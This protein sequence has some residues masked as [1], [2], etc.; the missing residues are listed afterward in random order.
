M[1]ARGG[2]HRMDHTLFGVE[3][4]ALF[5]TCRGYLNVS[6][7]FGIYNAEHN[8]LGEGKKVG[9]VRSRMLETNGIHLFRQI[10]GST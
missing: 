10:H 1:F 4:R 8:N 2:V 3:R 7:R 5:F 6:L 9:K